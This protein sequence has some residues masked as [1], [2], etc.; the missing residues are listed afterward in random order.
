MGHTIQFESHWG[1]LAHIIIDKLENNRE[2]LEYYGQP[3]PIKLN[4]TSKSGRRVR[5][6]HTPDFL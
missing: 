6:A 5:T 1:E 4:Y 3:L 2:V